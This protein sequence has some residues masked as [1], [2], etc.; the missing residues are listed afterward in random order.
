M[1]TSDTGAPTHSIAAPIRGSQHGFTR[2]RT[3]VEHVHTPADCTDGFVEAFWNRP[4]AFLDAAVRASQSTWSLLGPERESAA[5]ER[6][7]ADL[8]SGA[9]DAAHGHLR[10]AD[11]FDGALR[12]VI[13][14]PG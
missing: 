14:E 11:S 1:T 5:V 13:S 9:W 4:E 10:Q 8:E 2:R 6:L 12:L 7:R 3:S